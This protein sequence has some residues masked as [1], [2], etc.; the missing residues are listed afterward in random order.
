MLRKR[1]FN[2]G[3]RFF[4]FD[5]EVLYLHLTRDLKLHARAAPTGHGKTSS[6]P[7]SFE[8]QT[9]GPRSSNG[10]PIFTLRVR[11][12]DIVSQSIATAIQDS[13]CR[14]QTREMRLLVHVTGLT[15]QAINDCEQHCR[16]HHYEERAHGS[17][18]VRRSD[19]YQ[20]APSL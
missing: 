11:G 17:L 10:A 18:A 1:G 19:S 8:K 3:I 6:I 16:C 9:A 2:T 20:K 7:H 12:W 13:D 5:F 15:I 4:F 14:I